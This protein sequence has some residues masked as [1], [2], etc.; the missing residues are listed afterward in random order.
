MNS[1][2]KQSLLLAHPSLRRSEILP[3]ACAPS[4]NRVVLGSL[5]WAETKPRAGADL[6]AAHYLSGPPPF[7]FLMGENELCNGPSCSSLR[8][9]SLH[10]ASQCTCKMASTRRKCSSLTVILPCPHQSMAPLCSVGTL[11]LNFT[12]PKVPLRQK[13]IIC[14]LIPFVFSV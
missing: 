6:E 9:K 10:V 7:H 1:V 13:K 5:W 3:A 4:R 11:G 2:P 12:E 8:K 14:G